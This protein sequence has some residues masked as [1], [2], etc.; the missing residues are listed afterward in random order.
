MFDDEIDDDLVEITMPRGYKRCY[1]NTYLKSRGWI[2]DD[3]EYFP[4]GT[5]RA[6]EREYQDYIILEVLDEGRRVGFV[7]RSILSKE[8]IDSTKPDIIIRYAGT[9]IQMSGM[10][11]V[12][13]KCCITTMQ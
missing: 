9:K 5:N 10:A 1:K 6:I 4:V 11:M 7:A 3:Y 13:P 8:E 12:L 2:T